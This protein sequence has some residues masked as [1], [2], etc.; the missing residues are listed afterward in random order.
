MCVSAV[1]L[2]F[3]SVRVGPFSSAG[4]GVCLADGQGHTPKYTHT[5]TQLTLPEGLIIGPPPVVVR[6]LRGIHTLTQHALTGL[7]QCG[8]VCVSEC[9]YKLYL[10]C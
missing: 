4:E 6:P 9:V 7:L 8:C 5:N 3:H 1:C 2:C 10:S